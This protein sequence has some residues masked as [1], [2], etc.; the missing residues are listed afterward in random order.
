M[1]LESYEDAKNWLYSLKNRGTT[2]GI[3]RMEVFAELLGN[4]Q[5]SF[6]SIHIAGTNGKGSAAAMLESMFRAHGY[7]TGLSTSPHLVRQG[8]RI[9]VNREILSEDK[10]LECTRELKTVGTRSKIRKCV[11]VSSSS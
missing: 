3:E 6:P 7:K 2:Y 8:E 5:D 10:I 4:P 1:N 11:P 9:Q